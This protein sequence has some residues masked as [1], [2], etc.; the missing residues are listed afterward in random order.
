MLISTEFLNSFST[1]SPES[2]FF[3]HFKIKMEDFYI[4]R[5]WLHNWM[6]I[7]PL[8]SDLVCLAENEGTQQS[9]IKQ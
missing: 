1:D 8:N 3:S 2:S 9:N 7:L 6:C 5:Q 4:L